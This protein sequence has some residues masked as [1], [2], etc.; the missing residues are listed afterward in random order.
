MPDGSQPIPLT[1]TYDAFLFDMDGTLLNSIA[2]VERVWRNWAHLRGVDANEL[3]T[4]I[5]G[6]RAIDAITALNLPGV[7]AATDS[8][9]LLEEE[10]S[11]TEGI[12]AISG[13]SAFLSSLPSDRCAIVT[14]APRKL[15][16]LRLEA[17]GI[18]LPKVLV[19]AEDVVSG[20]PDPEGYRLGAQRL[21]FDPRDC[22]VF[23]DAPAGIL[24]GERAG[25]DVVV[26][27]A[28]HSVDH[29]TAHRSVVNYDDLLAV[30]TTDGVA[31]TS[32]RQADVADQA[33]G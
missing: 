5:H 7:D 12:V 13:V 4:K 21:G 2:L 16:L 9:M 1:K 20:K 28:T 27:T 26:V 6:V 18:P 23:E 10:M 29:V 19:T 8:A 14:S 30:V 17:V 11:T 33:A 3:L 32:V 25:S 15:A 24:A 22:L 31:L